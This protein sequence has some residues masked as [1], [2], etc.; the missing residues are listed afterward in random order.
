[1][2]SSVNT[3][4]MKWEN[5]FYMIIIYLTEEEGFL[6]L[7]NSIILFKIAFVQLFKTFVY[8]YTRVPV[9]LR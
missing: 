5:H 4:A 6:V 9:R 1:M 3:K 2:Y 8:M 7:D